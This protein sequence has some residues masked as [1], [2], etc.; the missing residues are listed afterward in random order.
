MQYLDTRRAKISANSAEMSCRRRFSGDISQS[1]DIVVYI[2]VVAVAV[3]EIT[4]GFALIRGQ[5]H[6]I[7]W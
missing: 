3:Q 4:I 2:D 5:T 6:I 7:E 1:N